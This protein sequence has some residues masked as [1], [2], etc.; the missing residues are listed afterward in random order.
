L[1]RP[2]PLPPTGHWQR[3]Y[4]FDRFSVLAAF[5]NGLAL[6]VIAGWIAFEAWGRLSEPSE[7]MG[8]VMLWVALAGLGVSV[9]AFL[10]L[11]RGKGENLN[12]RAAALHIAGDLLGS[13]AA[14]VAALV[15]LWTGWT[16][17]D[18]LLSVV[19]AL[20]ILR[21]GLVGCSAER[22]HPAGGGS[23]RARQPRGGGGPERQRH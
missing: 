13:V 7:V 23:A 8:E 1:I 5:I 21:S 15:I 3:T 6:F 18:P 17:I 14:L 10:V 20:V 12:V 19:V 4:G 22:A 16:P 2:A 9:L 11:S